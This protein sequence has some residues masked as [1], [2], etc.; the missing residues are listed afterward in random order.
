MSYNEKEELEEDIKDLS[1][2]IFTLQR[3][4]IN[5]HC[6]CEI[7]IIATDTGVNF[8]FHPLTKEVVDIIVKQLKERK[9]KYQDRIKQLEEQ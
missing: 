3:D 9:Q 6:R 8:Y 7:H 1:N 2:I 5:Q 4:M